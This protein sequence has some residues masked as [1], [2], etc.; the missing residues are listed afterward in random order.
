MPDDTLPGELQ[1]GWTEEYKKDVTIVTKTFI[2]PK[3]TLETAAAS[4]RVGG[5]YNG[6]TITVSRIEKI[7][8]DQAKWT[9]S[10]GTDTSDGSGTDPDR[11]SELWSCTVS[12]Y[13][14]PL[15]KYLN[16]TEAGKL[17]AWEMEEPDMQ[18]KILETERDLDPGIRATLPGKSYDV[19]KLKFS[20]TNEVIRCYPVATRVSIYNKYKKSIDPNLN[21]VD[22][23]APSGKFS[24]WSNMSWLK[25]QFDWEQQSDGTWKLTEAWQ[26][27]PKDDGGWKRKLYDEWDFFVESQNGN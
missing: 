2:G 19:A 1:I 4:H 24:V 26:G 11:L 18:L 16:E 13:Q 14:F 7:E 12:Q 5:K 3:T 27:A 25:V 6:S 10:Y 22:N 15:E 21:T 23:E 17:R 8:A 20:G 9:F